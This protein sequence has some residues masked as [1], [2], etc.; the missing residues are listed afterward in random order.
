MLTDGKREFFQRLEKEGINPFNKEI[1]KHCGGDCCEREACKALP[2]DINPF[3]AEHIWYLLDQGFYSI[4][5]FYEFSKAYAI[6]SAREEGYG[7]L[8][9][10]S[11][12]KRCS[13]LTK[14]GCLFFDQERPSG[15]IALIP[16]AGLRC[17]F[18]FE[19]GELEEY[20]KDVHVVEVMA[21]VL[22]RYIMNHSLE[23]FSE[24]LFR[25]FEYSVMHDCCSYNFMTKYAIYHAGLTYGYQFEDG[26]FNKLHS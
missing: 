5:T 4:R 11:P 12:H 21:E 17:R 23:K 16:Q 14:E 25:G 2:W 3:T 10:L 24:S 20:W 9:I 7:P 13:H 1:C 26:F 6:L 22:K 18:V 15:G 19:I 8:E